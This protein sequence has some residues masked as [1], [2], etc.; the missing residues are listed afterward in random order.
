MN[1]R[2]FFILF[3]ITIL[4]LYDRLLLPLSELFGELS[5]NTTS[6]KLVILSIFLVLI[7]LLYPFKTN[8]DNK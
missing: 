6:I 7:G 8:E 1:K 3:G 2:I 4:A 5:F